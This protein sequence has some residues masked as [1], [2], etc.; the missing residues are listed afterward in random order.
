MSPIVKRKRDKIK[1]PPKYLLLILTIVCVV[2][3]LVSFL[4]DINPTPVN[5]VAGYVIVPFQNGISAAGGYFKTKTDQL[6]QISELLEENASL[7]QQVDEL[8][9]E[10]TTL[11]QEKF[12]LTK[13]REL[14]ELDQKYS[15]YEKT[16][17]RVIM[18]GSGNW[19]NSFAINKGSDDGIEIDMNVIAGSGL[20]GRVVDVGPN[21]AKVI[22][23]IDDT[24]NVSGSVLSTSD[25]LIVSGDLE[26]MDQGYIRFQQLIDSKDAVAVGDKIVTSNISD[27]YLPGILIGYISYISTDSNNLTKSGYLTPAVDFEHLDEVLVI[28]EKKQT[29]ED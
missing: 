2:M 23:I 27:H 13:L 10:N 14:Y 1:I 15:D 22:T 25:K 19:F 11:Q 24:T 12:E 4:T 8:T 3:M 5:F 28:L 9:I 26:L 21:W 18:G 16:G 7:K 17:A 29:I 20:V 6:A